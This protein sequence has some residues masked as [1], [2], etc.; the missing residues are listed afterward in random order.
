MN[1]TDLPAAP[2]PAGILEA[3]LYAGDLDAACC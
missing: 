3:A 1:D 2:A